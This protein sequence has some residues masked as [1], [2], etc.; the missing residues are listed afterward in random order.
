MSD[1]HVKQRIALISL[2]ATVGVLI[3][4][5][6]VGIH[7]RSLGILAEA[8]HSALDLLATALTWFSLR[9]AA[10]PADANH[11]FG[12]G[13][14]ESFSAF[15]ETGLLALT[16]IAIAFA[17][18]RNLLLGQE[19]VHLDL[20]AYLVMATSMA[21]DWWRAGILRRA[22]AQF[23]S[24]A[25]AAD[26]LNYSTDLATSAAVLLGLAL[27]GVGQ[28][29]H[30]PWLLHTDAVAALIVATAML[31]LALRLG[32][33]TAGVLLDEAPPSLEGDLRA[34]LRGIEGIADLE[35]LRLRR[36]GSRYFVDVQLELEPASTLERASLVR[37]EIAD[38]IKRR[39]PE[40]DVIIEAEPR[41]SAP[42]GPFQQLQAIASRQNLS[43]HDL[44]IYN[45]DDGLDVEFHLELRETLPLVEAHNL[46]SR[47]EAEM[48]AALPSIRQIVTHI[49]PEAADVS[50]ASVLDSQRTARRVAQIARGVP[51]LR[52]CHDILLRRSGGHLVLSCHCSFPD[53]LP[54]GKVHELVTS[55]EAKIKRELPELF[56][57][58]IH[59]EPDSDNRR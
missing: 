45:V 21:V 22:A 31:G 27:V 47:L 11:P 25:L 41:R 34:A 36:A 4:K 32:R 38:R 16:A 18:F 30:I 37:R 19:A 10:R 39:L 15:L 14:F 7:T 42:L 24:D 51:E 23:S 33:R 8:A 3:F 53:S 49:E 55:L 6:V 9:I 43:I 52:D 26:A 56:R 57:L 13:K 44:S 1:D 12:H 20:W 59:P 29:A 58:T 17:A 2:A 35:R 40:A 54:V 46:V 28:R 5:L 48:R 50:A